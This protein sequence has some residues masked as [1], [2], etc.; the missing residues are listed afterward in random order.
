MPLALNGRKSPE[1]SMWCFT[2][3]KRASRYVLFDL[4]R[5]PVMWVRQGLLVPLVNKDRI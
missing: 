4:P 5:Q 3:L 1:P 2:L